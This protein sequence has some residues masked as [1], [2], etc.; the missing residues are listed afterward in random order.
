MK[1]KII[2]LMLI[3]GVAFF[4]SCKKDEKNTSAS[5][6]HIIEDNLEY[7]TSA[8]GSS[9]VA[10]QGFCLFVNSGFYVM[11]TE[12][13]GDEKTTKTK[14]S[15]S[16]ALGEKLL[17]GNTRRMLYEGDNRIYDFTE[18]HRLSNNTKGYVLAWQAAK[19]GQLAVVIGNNV[20]LYRTARIVDVSGVVLTRGSVIVYYPESETEGFVQAKGYD[21]G[22]KQYI[23][24]S[25]SYIRNDSFSGR[26]SDIQSAILL[27]TALSL[28]KEAQATQKEALLKSALEYY[29]DSIFYDEI[30]ETAF[31]DAVH[32]DGFLPGD[33][34][35]SETESND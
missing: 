19:G 25:N 5:E 12:D 2:I 17:V 30:F 1:K 16:I 31:P 21:I 3:I 26:E 4:Y 15:S 7:H 18:V 11:S 24:E 10:E 32:T 28:T 35:V 14:W 33:K 8:S 20:N 27:Q 9:S 34:S 13:T 6:E 29:A 22:R 23:A